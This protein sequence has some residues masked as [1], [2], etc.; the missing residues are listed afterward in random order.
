[1]RGLSALLGLLCVAFG[2]LAIWPWLPGG[3]E[4]PARQPPPAAIAGPIAEAELALPPLESLRATVER[5]LF[6]ATRSPARAAVETGTDLVLGRY[7]LT[8]V[9][10]A[11]ERTT[12]LLRPIGGGKVIRLVQGQELDGWK[13]VSITADHIVLA[14]GG[15]EQ[16]IPLGNAPRSGETGQTGRGGG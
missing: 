12:V 5:P 16:R 1:M 8:G 9:M 6:V 13:V 15:R 7:R 14:G 2:A 11:R 10:I 4:A 3:I